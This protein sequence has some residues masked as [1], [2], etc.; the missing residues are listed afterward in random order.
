MM[1]A[2][3]VLLLISIA[4]SAD[5]GPRPERFHPLT[6]RLRARLTEHRTPVIGF[7]MTPDGRRA[8][9]LGQDGVAVV[10]DALTWT[11][12]RATPVAFWNDN[13]SI[14]PDGRRIL[15]IGRDSRSLRVL[16]AATGAETQNLANVW[17]NANAF[18]VSPDSRR[19]AATM[20][21]RSIRIFDVAGTDDST[22]FLP[23]N[24]AMSVCW[25][26]DGRRIA[27]VGA[28]SAIRIHDAK[29]GA[30]VASFDAD[31][32]GMA[33]TASPDSRFLATLS[34]SRK[35]R[36]L[37]AETAREV[38]TFAPIVNNIRCVAFM[39]HSRWV[40]VAE[41]SGLVNVWD[42]E[43]GRE[44]GRLATEQR[45][46]M[47]VAFTPGGRW[48]V[49]GGSDGTIKV[50]GATGASKPAVAPAR[51]GRP[52]YL[53]IGAAPEDD[54]KG[55]PI[56]RVMEDLPAARA[57]LQ[58]G[59]VITSINAKATENFDDLRAQIA[60]MREGDEV[61]IVF[62]RGG[63]EKKAKFRLAARPEE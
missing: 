29:T 17:A 20:I 28:D 48:L 44:I 61:E 59:D 11:K 21:D 19:V 27:C 54:V 41:N 37:D 47:T 50:W 10:W 39:P 12:L 6:T 30:L 60:G 14:T 43:T 16:D 42:C 9:S 53:G 36:I 1:R 33:L 57:G 51:P 22:E 56:G 58:A 31:R 7:A 2:P 8:V 55:V 46:V 13:I 32:S 3:L 62:L 24:S 26:P 52:G 38:R 15:G 63:E 4:A 45:A 5:S 23:V 25:T 34:R 40:A 18:A 49:T 35:V